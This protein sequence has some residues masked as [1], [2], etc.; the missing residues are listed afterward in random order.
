MNERW[1]NMAIEILKWCKEF[2]FTCYKCPVC[3]LL[4][5]GKGT[6]YHW[7]V[8]GKQ[9]V[10]WEPNNDNVKEYLKEKRK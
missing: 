5:F 10:Y 6:S 7:Q 4:T 2:L 9:E 8:H 1:P 3:D